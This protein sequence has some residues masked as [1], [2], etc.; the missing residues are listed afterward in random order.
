MSGNEATLQG[1]VILISSQESSPA[2]AQH[3]AE[4][5]RVVVV[6]DGEV[7]CMEDA[8][9]SPKFLSTG[10]LKAKTMAES[11]AALAAIGVAWH[12]GFAEDS[13]RHILS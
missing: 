13:V 6:K 8:S 5:G 1:K 7:L 9:R 4:G 3:L 12:L 2:I 10:R 11:L